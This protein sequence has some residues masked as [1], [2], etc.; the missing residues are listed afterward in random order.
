MGE[1]VFISLSAM[2][3]QSQNSIYISLYQIGGNQIIRVTVE[4]ELRA[5]DPIKELTTVS[6]QAGRSFSSM[7]S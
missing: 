6:K 3:F 1:G 2:C 4:A 7:K 5:C